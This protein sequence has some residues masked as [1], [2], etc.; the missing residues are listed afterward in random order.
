MKTRW[1][2]AVLEN[3]AQPQPALPFHRGVRMA[4]RLTPVQQVVKT[5]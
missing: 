4:R 5:A 3:S 2:K 1:M